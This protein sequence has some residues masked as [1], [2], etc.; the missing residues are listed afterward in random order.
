[1]SYRGVLTL[2][3]KWDAN[4]SCPATKDA[5][6]A[7]RKVAREAKNKPYEVGLSMQGGTVLHWD[8]DVCRFKLR[9]NRSGQLDKTILSAID[10]MGNHRGWLSRLLRRT[11]SFDITE[12]ELDTDKVNMLKEMEIWRTEDRFP[13]TDEAVIAAEKVLKYVTA[14]PQRIGV[15]GEEGI[16]LRWDSPSY[17]CKLSIDGNGE[18][19]D[20][21]LKAIDMLPED[22]SGIYGAGGDMGAR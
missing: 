22:H 5:L 13:A 15:R 6:K 7:T 12:K 1:M 11:P 19:S 8:N 14:K 4:P 10:T 21:V 17:V 3:K 9:V 20:K 2:L 16:Q 18:V